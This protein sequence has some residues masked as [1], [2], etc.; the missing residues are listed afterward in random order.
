M[1]EHPETPTASTL[2]SV[3]LVS[4][5]LEGH[6]DDGLPDTAMAAFRDQ[7]ARLLL[8]AGAEELDV[9]G[10]ALVVSLRRPTNALECALEMQRIFERETAG[11]TG[12]RRYLLGIGIHRAPAGADPDW[13]ETSGVRV[14]TAL[15][16]IANGQIA[17]SGDFR[18][19]LVG[20]PKV[21]F[22]ERGDLLARGE[23][24]PVPVYLVSS[25]RGVAEFFNRMAMPLDLLWA[26][27]EIVLILWLVGGAV[28]YF[29]SRGENWS[30]FDFSL[31]PATRPIESVEVLRFSGG[32]LSLTSLLRR[33]AIQEDLN[34]SL[35]AYEGLRVVESDAEVHSEAVDVEAVLSGDASSAGDWL[36]VR[37]RLAD[38]SDE[39]ELWSGTYYRRLSEIESI[40]EAIAIDMGRALGL[41]APPAGAERPVAAAGAARPVDLESVRD[42]LEDALRQAQQLDLDD[43]SRITSLNNLA[44]LYYDSGRDDEAIPLYE[45]VIRLREATYGSD[46][47]EVAVGLNNLASLYIAR[48]RYADAEPLYRRS[49]DIRLTALGPKHPRVANAMSN[50]ALLHHRQGRLREAEELYA[51]ALEIRTLEAEMGPSPGAAELSDR[52]A[53]FEIEGNYAAAASTYERALDKEIA[54]S[55]ADDLRTVN[56]TRSLAVAR[57][58]NGEVQEA[59]SLLQ[60]AIS[61]LTG[62]VGAHHELTA[63]SLSDLGEVYRRSGRVAEAQT[64]HERALTAYENALGVDDA[65]VAGTLGYLVS[66]FELKGETE[67]AAEARA[68]REEIRRTYLGPVFSYVAARSA[69]QSVIRDRQQDDLDAPRPLHEYQLEIDEGEFVSER[70]RLAENLHNMALL[71]LDLRRL[72]EAE[73]YALQ[74][75]EMRRSIGDGMQ[76]EV[77]INLRGIGRINVLQERFPEAQARY[78]EALRIFEA[79]LGSVHPHVAEAWS[80]LA[81]LLEKIGLPGQA[82]YAADRARQT[83]EAL[84]AD[85]A[86]RASMENL[87]EAVRAPDAN[88]LSSVDP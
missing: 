23:S 82:V 40:S 33:D 46:H 55:G 43:A 26:R 54:H 80:D 68:R 37:A 79:T 3:A 29:Y 35:A 9:G 39:T 88:A 17:V 25:A 44:D 2:L 87:D 69:T 67:K 63:R 10:S 45:E 38:A 42:E 24:T 41:K 52:A 83:R 15:R 56:L 65:E 50:L 19:S 8:E 31:Q 76:P 86:R 58:E 66:I 4:K 81:E 72:D 36:L 77:G 14:V 71:Y 18:A 48:G 30:D 6:A 27:K 11:K 49:L 7:I 16:E 78:K 59:E 21:R 5:P 13:H 85:E 84:A 57:A 70:R 61:V 60:H 73:R 47:P 75:L 74:A 1:T 12:P 51:A 20:G 62:S 64:Y 32:S 28:L 22:Q 53:R 34:A